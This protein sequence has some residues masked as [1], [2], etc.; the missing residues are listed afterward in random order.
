MVDR[1]SAT[2]A[3]PTASVTG[4]SPG[5]I[6]GALT[7]LDRRFGAGQRRASYAAEADDPSAPGSAAGRSI[8]RVRS[9]RRCAGPAGVRQ[10]ATTSAVYAGRVP[11]TSP[12]NGNTL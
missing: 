4:P 5:R 10:T 8:G 11:H 3:S 9:H 1:R 12:A 2:D 7:R 6:G